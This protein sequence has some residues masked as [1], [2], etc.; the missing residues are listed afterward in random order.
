MREFFLTNNRMKERKKEMEKERK[1]KQRYNRIDNISYRF[2][3]HKS[4]LRLMENEKIMGLMQT[5]MFLI[6]ACDNFFLALD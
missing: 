3:I 5:F 4:S 1:K 6:L 2:I